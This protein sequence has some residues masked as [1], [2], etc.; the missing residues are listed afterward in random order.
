MDIKINLEI[1]KKAIWKNAGLCIWLISVA[2]GLGGLWLYSMDPGGFGVVSRDWP[3][4]SKIELSPDRL[5]LVMFVHPQCSCSRASLGELAVLMKRKGG[6]VDAKVMFIC[7]AD[8]ALTWV[9]S[10]LWQDAMDIPGVQVFVDHEGQEAG[11]FGAQTSGATIVYGADGTLLFHGG[12]TAARGHFGDNVGRLVIEQLAAGDDPGA[13]ETPVFGCALQ[14]SEDT[15][16]LVN[17]LN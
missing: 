13:D 17:P 6:L 8:E 9:Q 4:N 16:P 14:N 7:P 2:M 1:I 3:E 15:V 5:Q 11:L 12:I 10:G